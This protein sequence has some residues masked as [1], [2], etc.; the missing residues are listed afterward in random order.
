MLHGTSVFLRRSRSH[1]QPVDQSQNLGEQFF[2][3]GNFRHLEGDVARMGDD[4]RADLD[5]LFAQAGQ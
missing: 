3:H 4:L 5:Q 1:S 2:W